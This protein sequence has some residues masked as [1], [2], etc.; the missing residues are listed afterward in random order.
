MLISDFPSRNKLF[1]IEKFLL[2]SD[3]KKYVNFFVRIL[4]KNIFMIN[5]TYLQQN[6]NGN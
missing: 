4:G 2:K 3:F 5:C 1:Y 6:K